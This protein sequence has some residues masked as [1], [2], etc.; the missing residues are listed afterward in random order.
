MSLRPTPLS[1]ALV[2]SLAGSA[3]AADL[4][5]AYDLARQSDPQ[6]AAAEARALSQ[7]EGIVQSR[8]ALLPQVDITGNFSDSNGDN[9]S[10]R[11]IS[12]NPLFL[13]SSVSNNDSRTRSWNFG[14]RQ[15]LYDHANY[16]ALKASKAR[17]AKARDDFEAATQALAVRVADAYFGVL[18]SIEV[19]VSA[20]AEEVAVKRQ[21]D[22]AEKRLEVGLAPI[23]DVHEA[24]SRYDSARAASI[25][26]QNSYDDFRE[27]L[28]EV[29]GKAL[30][31]LKGLAPDFQ[32]ALPDNQ[33]AEAWVTLALDQN[34][35]LRSRLL[36]L[37][38]SE[39]D[40]ASARAGHLPT[41]NATFDYSDT[42]SWGQFVTGG[43]VIPSKSS[44]NDA[45]VGIQL[46]VPLF[47]GFA[48]Q[49]RVRQAIHTRDAVRDQAEQE[50]RAVTRQTR[51]AFRALLNGMSEIDARAQA[52]VSARSA[53][54][55]TEAGYEVGTRTIVDVLIGQQQLYAAQRE[56]ARSRH[57]FLVNSLRLKQAAGTVEVKDIKAVNAYLVADAEAALDQEAP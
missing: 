41:L 34:P 28:A 38:A 39:H 57:A 29:T 32:P 23:T 5:Q 51:N 25:A 46:R 8:A 52:L 53:L 33:E 2:L 44:G 43:S 26:A 20:R 45:T 12:L 1:L 31:G 54:E 3:N 16:T 10:V 42:E 6:L 7:R 48:T 9:R 55:A 47:A 30:N 4:T 50:R 19:L 22:Q 15:S 49:S 11:P 36:D 17:S 56:L 37:E 27:A 24:Q 21:L 18:T 14:V 35:T 40:I 13:S